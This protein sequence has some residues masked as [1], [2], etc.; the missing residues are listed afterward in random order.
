MKYK[1]VC[2]PRRK[3]MMRKPRKFRKARKGAFRKR[4]RRGNLYGKVIQMAYGISQSSSSLIKRASKLGKFYKVASRDQYVI[5]GSGRVDGSVGTQSTNVT[6]MWDKT[7]IAS[8]KSNLSLNNTA[9]I[10]LDMCDSV[11]RFTNQG[12][13]SVFLTLYHIIARRDN[14]SFAGPTN[15][16]QTGIVDESGASSAYTHFGSIPTNS[17]SFNNYFKIVKIHK[18]ALP[19]GAVHQHV[20]RHHPKRVISYEE[21]NN[22][23]Y[24]VRGLSSYVMWTVSTSAYNDSTTKT[25]VTLGIPHVDYIYS[26]TYKYGYISDAQTSYYESN[27]LSSSFA[28]NQ[29][30]MT[31][32]PSVVTGDTSA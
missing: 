22:V 7:D 16:W 31:L 28:V 26:K 1:P 12:I 2:V 14:S 32:V 25:S 9:R 27:N 21:V 4:S 18:V 6:A 11:F 19:A 24:G 10:Y 29:D 3:R 15:A 13:A 17:V 20:I 8:I 30:V 5:N 23:T